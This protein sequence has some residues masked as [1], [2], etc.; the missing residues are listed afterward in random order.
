MGKEFGLATTN[1]KKLQKMQKKMYAKKSGL[2]KKSANQ[3]IPKD[4]EKFKEGRDFLILGDGTIVNLNK[5]EIVKR[6]KDLTD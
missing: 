3:D 5:G 2:P 4:D 1:V 6:G